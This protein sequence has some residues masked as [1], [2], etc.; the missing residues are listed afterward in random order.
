[1]NFHP[2][3]HPE[4][5]DLS[6]GV[7]VRIYR[8]SC[9]QPRCW[10]LVAMGEGS[11]RTGCLDG[12]W[13]E[14]TGKLNGSQH[15]QWYE[16]FIFGS[17]DFLICKWVILR[18]QRWN[19]SGCNVKAYC[20]DGNNKSAGWD[21]MKTC[22]DFGREW[23]H[24]HPFIRIICHMTI[25]LINFLWQ[26]SRHWIGMMDSIPSKKHVKYRALSS[27]YFRCKLMQVAI[28]H[29]V[30]TFVMVGLWPLS[31][32]VLFLF[33][34][35]KKLELAALKRKIQNFHVW[36]FDLES[37]GLINIRDPDKSRRQKYTL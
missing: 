4:G 31:G 8:A 1:M 12:F 37:K 14:N 33:G 26:D 28:C 13:L 3:D 10:D 7:E 20:R 21:D 16:G 24:H 6:T 15:A 19:F 2:S 36:R 11:F 35:W 17:D 22:E 29:L 32:I 5:S 18:F 23:I 34:C 30:V 25:W 27:T 9:R